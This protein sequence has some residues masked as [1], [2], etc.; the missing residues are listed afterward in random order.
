MA[1]ELVEHRV[2]TRSWIVTTRTASEVVVASGRRVAI[3]GPRCAP[4]SSCGCWQGCARLQS[5]RVPGRRADEALFVIAGE[6]DGALFVQRRDCVSIDGVEHCSRTC[7]ADVADVTCDDAIVAVDEACTG[8]CVPSEAFYRCELH[9]DGCRAI[10]HP[11][12]RAS[13]GQ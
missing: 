11:T 13:A 2:D 5:V 8:A 6:L 1:P 7:R 12:R 4:R 10:D 9:E 3:G